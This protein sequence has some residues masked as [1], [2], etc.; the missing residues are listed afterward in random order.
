LSDDEL[1]RAIDSLER[2]Q[3]SA[4][5]MLTLANS[6]RLVFFGVL[7]AGG[8]AILIVGPAPFIELAEGQRTLATTWDVFAWWFAVLAIASIAGAIAIQAARRRRRRAAGWK[9]RVD[10]LDR[11]LME[12]TQEQAARRAR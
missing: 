5:R 10:D 8:F 2:K 1:A 6:A 12:A 11:R 7:L 3:R 9:H 4:K